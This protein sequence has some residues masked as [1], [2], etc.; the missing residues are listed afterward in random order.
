M[1]KSFFLVWLV[2]LAFGLPALGQEKPSLPN[3]AV[4]VVPGL[5]GSALSDRHG[6]MIWGDRGSLGR[7]GR[8]KIPNGPADPGDD[9]KP[10][11]LIQSVQVL[12]P[13]K[14]KVYDDLRKT[15][16]EDMGYTF[17]KN[18]FE[19][20]YDWRQSNFTTAKL[21]RKWVDENLGE[22]PFDIVA[23]SMGGLVSEIFIKRHDSKRQVKRFVT[24]G[25]PFHGA[26][27]SVVTLNEGLGTLANFMVGGLGKFR[28]IAL[29]FP[30]TYELLPTYPNCCNVMGSGA[31]PI[32]Y[33]TMTEKGWN[34]VDWNVPE[35]AKDA[36]KQRTK[37]VLNQARE[38]TSLVNDPMPGHLEQYIRIAGE[39]IDT[40]MRFFVDPSTRTISDYRHGEG[41]GTVIVRSAS[42]GA[43]NQSDVSF[44]THMVIFDDKTTVARL[45]RIF[46]SDL[47]NE[48]FEY[49]SQSYNFKTLDGVLIP[50][51]TMGLE[52]EPS[53]VA[54]GGSFSV[55]VSLSS[56]GANLPVE[57]V[58]V[59]AAMYVDGASTATMIALHDPVLTDGSN[60]RRAVYTGEAVAPAAPTTVRIEVK[61]LGIDKPVV[62]FLLVPALPQAEGNHDR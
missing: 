7:F 20:A 55:R 29:S 52:V 1:G 61:A 50:M 13:W 27:N 48:P 39:K 9:L 11:G 35:Y 14:A 57:S 54:G 26:V 15:F 19:F 10:S 6:K 42:K 16:E 56:L 37:V 28:S 18:Y 49:A 17:G 2:V 45:K 33:D 47:Y 25:T 12:G 60:S 5:L 30:S 21:L 62:D 3:R 43:V 51:Q 31:P 4:V 58:P 40:K 44:S 41:D 59:E 22:R 53:V 38:L 32:P 8:L 36:A 24:M 34:Q 46:R 23:H